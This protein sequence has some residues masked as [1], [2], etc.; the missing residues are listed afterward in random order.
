MPEKYDIAIIGAGPCAT[1]CSS[2]LSDKGFR[3]VLIDRGSHPGWHLPESITQVPKKILEKL[4]FSEKDVSQFCKTHSDVQFLNSDGSIQIGVNTKFN[5]PNDHSVYWIDRNKFDHMLLDKSRDKGTRYISQAQITNIKCNESNKNVLISFKK[6]GKDQNIC[7]DFI[8]DGS[9]K[10]SVLPNAF[11]LKKSVSIKLDNRSLVFSHFEETSI[12]N[13]FRDVSIIVTEDGY[14]FVIPIRDN[15]ISIGCVVSENTFK[16]FQT[17]QALL[18]HQI[19]NTPYLENIYKNSKQVLPAIPA[20]NEQKIYENLVGDDYIILGEAG[21]FFDPFLSNGLQ[22][23]LS[24]GILGAEYIVKRSK[25]NNSKK[26]KG[27][28]TR[29]GGKLSHM[30]DFLKN[31]KNRDLF[32]TEVY[33]FI[34]G[35]A[36]P[37]LPFFIPLSLISNFTKQSPSQSRNQ[38]GNQIFETARKAY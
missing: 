25:E 29:Y 8:V 31:N 1:T 5:L 4:D 22:I 37:H 38:W 35:C 2:I 11:N 30:Y 14:L 16:K 23:A 17:P 33:K 7:C 26:L 32:N 3:C 18:D 36:D 10:S 20:V 27:L 12:E 15:R 21:A 6:D 13:T 28:M 34:K 19:K 24:T 9:G